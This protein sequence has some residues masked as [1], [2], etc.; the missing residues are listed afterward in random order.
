MSR[1][2]WKGHEAFGS[3]RRLGSRVDM[4]VE[5]RDKFKRR[6]GPMPLARTD[7]CELDN[8]EVPKRVLQRSDSVR[9]SI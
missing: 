3:S 5:H 6:L 9:Y 8:L 2:G 1:R 7:G 4:S